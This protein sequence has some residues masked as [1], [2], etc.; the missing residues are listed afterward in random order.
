MAFGLTFKRLALN[1]VMR[2]LKK[3]RH[4]GRRK[5]LTPVAH[6][7]DPSPENSPR[8]DF[9]R[10]ISFFA[11]VSLRGWVYHPTSRL[12]GIC[13]CQDE[14]RYGE[15]TVNRPSP[16]VD[17]G[18]DLRFEM[19]ALVPGL[20]WL[21]A[22]VELTFADGS[23]TTLTAEEIDNQHQRN[24]RAGGQEFGGD[25]AFAAF[26]RRLP[27]ISTGTMLEIGSRARSDT[28]RRDWFPTMGYIG[29]DILPGDNVDL[30][31]DAHKLSEKL[32]RASVD[33]VFSVSTFEH[34]LMPWKVIVELNRVMRLGAVGYIR[35]H[36]TIG[37]HDLPWDYWRF[38]DLAWGALFNRRTG[39]EIEVTHL[40]EPMF[41][42]PFEMA[43][44]WFGNERSAGFAVSAVTFRKVAE[45][46]LDWDVPLEEISSAPYPA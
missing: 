17:L 45:T 18:P 25:T 44:K 20:D 11:F 6:D 41:I 43:P 26:V 42:V 5:M 8:Y 33:G 29:V 19:L 28:I 37:L 35:T 31:C 7:A 23:V 10:F 36:Q 13:V 39:F 4:F 46:T 1:R 2:R 40:G 12:S 14:R 9:D 32:P 24:L 27:A 16:D 21:K 3:I 15:A 38:S 34:L 22:V 30:V